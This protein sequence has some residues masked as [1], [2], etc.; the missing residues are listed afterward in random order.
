MLWL[1]HVDFLKYVNTNIYMQCTLTSQVTEF[2][3]TETR[4][5]TF[6]AGLNT[7]VKSSLDIM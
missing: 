5:I 7:Q 6:P 4:Q 2:V 1:V 3:T